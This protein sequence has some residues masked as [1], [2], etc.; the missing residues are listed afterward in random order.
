MIIKSIKTS[1][2][3]LACTLALIGEGVA[4]NWQQESGTVTHQEK[5]RGSITG[6]REW[7]DLT[8]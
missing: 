7:W 1:L 5:L 6:E 4:S 8:H 2:V 3:G